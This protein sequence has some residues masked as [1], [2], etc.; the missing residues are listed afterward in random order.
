MKKKDYKSWVCKFGLGLF[1]W[2]KVLPLYGDNGKPVTLTH[3]VPLVYFPNAD[4]AAVEAR[5]KAEGFHLAW[6]TI[7]YVDG[8]HI[9]KGYTMKAL[10]K[11]VA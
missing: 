4:Y 2:L 3:P 10:V 8:Y 5:V 9:P 7:H 1:D 6:S 11:D